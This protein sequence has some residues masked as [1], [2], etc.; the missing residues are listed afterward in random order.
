MPVLRGT[1]AAAVQDRDWPD[2]ASLRALRQEWAQ[3]SPEDRRRWS[4]LTDADVVVRLE[5]MVARVLVQEAVDGSQALGRRALEA[6]ELSR[7]FGVTYAGAA[8]EPSP[9]DA[10]VALRLDFL[11]RADALDVLVR[12]AAASRRER[13][14]VLALA[15]KRADYVAR[16]NVA[17]VVLPPNLTWRRVATYYCTHV[18]QRVLD[19]RARAKQ[20]RAPALSQPRAPPSPKKTRLRAA[21][22]SGKSASARRAI[23]LPPLPTRY[24]W[25]V[26]RTFVAWPDAETVAPPRR[27][28]SC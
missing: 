21:R 14:E 4:R 6:S 5:A 12:A 11:T 3:W 23:C 10:G 2:G 25:I 9:T 15:T 19:Q 24:E 27:A 1:T 16:L 17:V 20:E 8:S 28:R 18:L 7:A 26:R 13:D 22:L